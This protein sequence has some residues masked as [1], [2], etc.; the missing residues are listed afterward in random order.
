MTDE[1]S[2]P[3][4][5]HALSALVAFFMFAILSV[6][7]VDV[8]GRY[9]FNES[10]YGGFEMIAYLLGLLIFSGFPIVSYRQEHIV[11]GLLDSVF[12]GKFDWYRNLIILIASAVA[13]AFI[14]QRVWGVAMILDKD[15]QVGQV[16][17][18][19]IAPY[20]YGMACLSYL[21]ALLMLI[22]IWNVV[23]AGPSATAA[24]TTTSVSL[25]V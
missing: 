6:M 18:I 13:L 15:D 19:Q 4:Y 7:T 22:V 16:L 20:V 23:K 3:W 2:S 24:S 21:A 17:D 14:S 9:V 8:I 10:L 1:N 12:K 11:V 5:I 25:D